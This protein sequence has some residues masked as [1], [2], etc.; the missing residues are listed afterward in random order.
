MPLRDQ[1]QG[2][3]HM[4]LD[5]NNLLPNDSSI[6]AQDHQTAMNSPAEHVV[7]SVIPVEV[8][9][10]AEHE[11]PTSLQRPETQRPFAKHS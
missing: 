1:H 10:D 2:K 5:D 8:P 6:M 9:S 7:V 4:T 11:N 3:K